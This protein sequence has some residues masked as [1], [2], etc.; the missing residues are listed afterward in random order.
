MLMLGDACWDLWLDHAMLVQDVGSWS[1][2]V[3]NRWLISKRVVHQQS[4]IKSW[5]VKLID[6]R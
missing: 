3:F 6:D 2:L 5:L 1:M 4:L